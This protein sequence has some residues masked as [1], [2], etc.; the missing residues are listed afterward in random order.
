M[1]EYLK[2]Y[3]DGEWTDPAELKTLDVDNP[4]IEEVCG[5]I[6]RGSSADVDRAVEAARKAFF[7]WSQTSREERLT[8]LSRIAEAYQRRIGDLAAAISEEMGAPAALAGG[9]QVGL[10]VAHLNTAIA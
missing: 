4:A 10:G 9:F 8:V 3:I 5:K 6:A 7:S 1:R 2:F